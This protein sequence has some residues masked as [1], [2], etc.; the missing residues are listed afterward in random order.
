MKRARLLLLSGLL[1]CAPA[2]APP[3]AAELTQSAPEADV[4][5]VLDDWHDAAAKAD[6]AR[7]FGHFAQGGVF[8]GTDGKERWTVPAFRAYAHPH[9]AKGKA[10]SFRATRREI[11]WSGKGPAFSEEISYLVIGEVTDPRAATKGPRVR[12]GARAKK[13]R[14]R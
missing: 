1:A 5:R 3:R 2:T 11:T 4:V 7:Y 6:E 10:W 9:F 14:R 8:L 12:K 13:T